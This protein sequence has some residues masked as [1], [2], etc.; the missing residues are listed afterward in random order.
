METNPTVLIVDDDDDDI[1]LFFMAMK[2]ID[3]DAVCHVANDCEEALEKL[4]REYDVDVLPDYIFLDL[5][6][7]RI[8]GKTCLAELKKDARLKE[9]PVI[10]YTTSAHHRDREETLK[11]GA[12]YFLTK[13]SSFSKIQ[14][15]IAKA[16]KTVSSG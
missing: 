4:R 12:A 2:K 11:L 16:I 9:I 3:P 13:A 10:I 7:P 14:E 1:E 8:D 6:M 15:G 5:N